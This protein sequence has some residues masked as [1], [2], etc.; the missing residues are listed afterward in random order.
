MKQVFPVTLGANVGTTV[1]AFL[2]SFA[3]AS[4]SAALGVQ[5]A[6]VH[7]FFNLAGI[8]LIYPIEPIRNIPL[9]AAN[10]LGTVA[11]ASKKTA[12]LYILGLFYGVPA[13]LITISKTF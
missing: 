1:T 5:I 10:W 8:L 2:A 3:V 11:V 12:V 13:L 9:R 7:L 6:L 4:G